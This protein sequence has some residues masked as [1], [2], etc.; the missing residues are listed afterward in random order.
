MF[1]GSEES[2]EDDATT[3]LCTCVVL[4]AG[5]TQEQTTGLSSWKSW[6]RRPYQGLMEA[7]LEEK[8][9]RKSLGVTLSH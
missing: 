5:A 9:G 8:E 6:G 7:L 3:T 1:L 4:L 2:G